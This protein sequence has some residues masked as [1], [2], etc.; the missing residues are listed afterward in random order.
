MSGIDISLSQ[1]NGEVLLDDT[2]AHD[3]YVNIV[4]I[5]IINIIIII[6]VIIVISAHKCR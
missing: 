1:I 2:T 4:T 3:M 5:I 6:V